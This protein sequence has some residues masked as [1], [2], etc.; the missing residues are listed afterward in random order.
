MGIGRRRGGGGGD[1][2][3]NENRGSMALA[4]GA[5]FH[6]LMRALSSKFIG[7]QTLQNSGCPSAALSHH[8]PL[9][10]PS[11]NEMSVW[12]WVRCRSRG[13][14]SHQ[15]QRPH[16]HSMESA[17]P[18][19]DSPFFN[20]HV[21]FRRMAVEDREIDPSKRS[22][23]EGGMVCNKLTQSPKYALRIMASKSHLAH[24]NVPC[25]V[26]YPP[27]GIPVYSVSHVD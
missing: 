19:A 17:L 10:V 11:Q 24:D 21:C 20:A 7:S 1:E 18:C 2:A 6:H 3:E 16:H 13:I 26:N 9:A 5:V 15:P 8:Q 14:C 12:V 4:P 27:D 22:D 25:S 23:R